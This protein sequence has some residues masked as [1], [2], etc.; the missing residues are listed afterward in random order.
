MIHFVERRTDVLDA[1]LVVTE[2]GHCLAITPEQTVLDLAH[3][4]GLGHAPNEAE[5]A[6]QGLLARCDD[7]VLG[8]IAREQ[9]LGAALARVRRPPG[10]L[11]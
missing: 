7:A 4:P 8:R 2:L 1:E 6:I 5:A 3:R 9:R 11:L 10:K